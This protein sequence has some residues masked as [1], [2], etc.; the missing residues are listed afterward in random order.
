MKAQKLHQPQPKA[1][2]E[3]AKRLFVEYRKVSLKSDQYMS[4]L[5]VTNSNCLKYNNINTLLLF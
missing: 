2:R 3:F 5:M 1:R 4:N